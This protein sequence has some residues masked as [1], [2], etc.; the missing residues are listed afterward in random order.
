MDLPDGTVSTEFVCNA[1]DKGSIPGLGRFPGEGNGN[2]FQSSCLG[3]PMDRGA[4]WAIVH[5][6][7]KRHDFMTTQQQHPVQLV[8]M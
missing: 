6:V 4:W 3:T 7:A 5:G 2:P 8:S 1:R